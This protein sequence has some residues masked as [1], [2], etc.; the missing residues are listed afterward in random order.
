MPAMIQLLDHWA[1]TALLETGFIVLNYGQVTRTTLEIAPCSP[2]FTPI[3]VRIFDNG[4]RNFEV[5]RTTS[6]LPSCRDR[7]LH[8]ASSPV[9]PF[10]CIQLEKKEI[11][12]AENISPRHHKNGGMF[13][14]VISRSSP[15]RV[16]L[17]E[18]SSGEKMELAFIH[19]TVTNSRSVL[20]L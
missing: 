14:S 11:C 10:D 20:K 12:G 8:S 13:F 17:P 18:Y 1:T 2:N 3:Y 15:D 4:S 9:C 6:E 16:I 7:P 5:M 19:S